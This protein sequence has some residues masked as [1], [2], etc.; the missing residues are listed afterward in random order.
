MESV[1]NTSVFLF[2][3]L[4]KLV[5]D[6]SLFICIGLSVV[7]CSVVGLSV[8]GFS[9]N[10]SAVIG[11]SNNGSVVSSAAIFCGCS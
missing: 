9:N 11:F 3:V 7:G 8:V 10:G 1:F 4:D 2:W 5:L 6:I